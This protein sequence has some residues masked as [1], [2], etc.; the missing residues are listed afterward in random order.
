MTATYPEE[1]LS[2]PP[3][4]PYDGEGAHA[5]WHYSEDPGLARFAPHVVPTNPSEPAAVWAVDTRHAPMFWFPRDCPRGCVWVGPDTTEEDRERFFGQSAAA[6]IHA[7]ES[8]WLDRMRT[9]TLY[10]YQLPLEPFRAHSVGGYWVTEE[11]VEAQER[12]LV[13]DLLGRHAAAGIEVRVT[14]SVWPFWKR[15]AASTLHFSGSRLRN[16]APHA[17]SMR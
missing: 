16:A 6:R 13:D 12:L 3:A 8:A 15:V 4:P 7:I 11:T 10:A 9:T 2:R 14:P 1:Q 17:D 5:L